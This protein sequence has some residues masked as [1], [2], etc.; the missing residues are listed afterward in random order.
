MPMVKTSTA[1]LVMDD[2]ADDALRL[3]GRITAGVAHDLNNY[4]CVTNLLLALLQTAPTDPVLL[5]RTRSSLEQARRLTTSLMRQVRGEEL[6]FEAVDFA[7][8]VNSTLA[9]LAQLIPPSI[10]VSTDIAAY[11]R[12]VHGI[13]SELEQMVMNL[14]LNAADAM[15]DGGELTVRVRTTGVAM[16]CLEVADTG[17]GMTRDALT[18]YGGLTASSR[19]GQR[20]GLGLGIVRR[21]I[22][23][24]GG[25][26]RFASRLDRSGTVAWAMLPTS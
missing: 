21:V 8:L 3:L 22:E 13:A 18:S 25:S 12:P 6:A 10:Q 5:A 14:V 23:H 19:P 11:L 1:E 4:L 20:V 26:I 15:P 17:A 2:G 16:L 24:H 7:E 9:L